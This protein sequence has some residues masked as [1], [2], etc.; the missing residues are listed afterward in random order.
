MTF[1]CL[2]ENILDD[3]LFINVRQEEQEN[4]EKANKNNKY[5]YA[6]KNEWLFEFCI[7]DGSR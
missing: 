2:K 1:Q 6:I 4:D 7:R 3:S 5:V